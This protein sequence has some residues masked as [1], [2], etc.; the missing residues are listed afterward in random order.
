MKR[1]IPKCI[2]ILQEIS[3]LFTNEWSVED[4]CLLG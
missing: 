3:K 2:E 4:D 1:R